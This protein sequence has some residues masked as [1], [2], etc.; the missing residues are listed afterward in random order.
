MKCVLIN[1]STE[2]YDGIACVAATDER[3]MSFRNVQKT[4]M[5]MFSQCINLVRVPSTSI[6]QSIVKLPKWRT[7]STF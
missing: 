3:M 2:R 7:F 6:N 1:I 4:A 5:A